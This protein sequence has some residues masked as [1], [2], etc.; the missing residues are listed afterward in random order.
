[1][2]LR[3]ITAGMAM[4]LVG[5]LAGCGPGPAG[6]AEWSDYRQHQANDDAYLAQR[7]A[8]AAQWQARAGDY[9]GAQLSQSAANA[10]AAKAQQ[11][12]AH[13]ARDQWFSRF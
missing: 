1:M 12:Q 2:H 4:A 8:S 6:Y 7:N 13:A 9:Q 5:G 10:E 11:E 3:L